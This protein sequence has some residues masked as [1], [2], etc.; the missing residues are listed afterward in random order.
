[1]ERR[2]HLNRLGILKADVLVDH[3]ITYK[4]FHLPI[5][6]QMFKLLNFYVTFPTSASSQQL[7]PP[8]H[9]PDFLSNQDKSTFF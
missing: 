5:I 8:Q 1:M 7:T 6:N 2:L 9:P 4:R 3:V